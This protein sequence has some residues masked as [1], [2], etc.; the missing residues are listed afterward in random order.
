MQLVPPQQLASQTLTRLATLSSVTVLGS[1][2]VLGSVTVLGSLATLPAQA[3]SPDDLRRL[4]TSKA[5]A[6][7]EL[8]DAGLVFAN[9]EQAELG[10]ANL[11]RANLSRATLSG[12]NLR[13]ANLA[14]AVLYGANLYNADLTGADLRGADLR[15]AYLGGAKF[16]GGQLEGPLLQGVLL[17]GAIAIPSDLV[18]A[19]TYHN[20]AMAEAQASRHEAA[21]NYYNQAL[22]QDPNL[23]SAYLGRS[24]SIS[25]LGQ[26][27]Q[28]TSDAEQAQALFVAAGDRPGADTA[29]QVLQM[30]AQ[31][32]TAQAELAANPQQPAS[33]TGIR[34]GSSG[35]RGW[36]SS[37]VGLFRRF[38]P[39][40]FNFLL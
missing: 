36:G 30:I 32:R 10:Q 27:D 11:S 20:W 3:A 15:G 31:A 38:A 28:A 13:G 24:F 29:A 22:S 7:C 8:G 40:V 18:S 1:I 26:L 19:E 35:G 23:A 14:G 17:Q 37:I 21:V 16:G 9:L 12:A 34:Q 25:V 6:G 4:L 39:M 5:C 2:T 33:N